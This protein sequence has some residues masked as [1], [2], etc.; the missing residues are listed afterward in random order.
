[1]AYNADNHILELAQMFG[2][3]KRSGTYIYV[4]NSIFETRLCNLFLSEEKLSKL[5]IEP[6]E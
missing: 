6:V 2:Y 1:M 4:A 3:V 5:L